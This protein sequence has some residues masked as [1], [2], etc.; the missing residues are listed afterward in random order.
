[1]KTVYVVY[2][3]NKYDDYTYDVAASLD[4]DTADDIRNFLAED[5]TNSYDVSTMSLFDSLED[6]IEW[7]DQPRDAE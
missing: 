2:R 3:Y 7:K 6:F 1:M 4:Y 5:I